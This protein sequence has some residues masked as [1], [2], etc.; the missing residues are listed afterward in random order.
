MKISLNAPEAVP[1]ARDSRIRGIRNTLPQIR[2][3][4]QQ[5]LNNIAILDYKLLWQV[6]QI[7]M[8]LA[9]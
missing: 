3:Y 2:C 6:L 7:S 5:Q 9:L 8:S 4:T 1:A